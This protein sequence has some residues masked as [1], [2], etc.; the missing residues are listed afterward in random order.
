MSD[1][2]SDADSISDPRNAHISDDDDDDDDGADDSL[3]SSAVRELCD[4]LRA[5]DPRVLVHDSSVIP[6]QEAGEYSER[7]RIK[8]FQA[9]KENT[10][11]KHIRLWLHGYTKSS[12]RAA[13]KCLESSQTL[14]TIDLLYGTN[15]Q[16]L[17]AVISPLLRAL[18]RNASVTKLCVD[19]DIVGV[20]S[21]AFQELLTCTQTL[22]TMSVVHYQRFRNEELDEADIAVITSGFSNNTTLRDLEFKGWRE[23]DLAPV[24]TAL[25]EHPALQK[26]RFSTLP[27][28][29]CL[30][31]LSGIEVL[32]TKP[33][34]ENQGISS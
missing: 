9:L 14:Q 25:Q 23:A 2:D 27:N 19:T 12:A 21:V 16:H 7:E 4:R 24:L 31:S 6:F 34:F 29:Y 32:F 3:I 33:G 13:A 17:P 18:S 5:N 26:I 15:Y 20:A 22:Q 11:V 28:A 8:V 30:P 10:S 1:A